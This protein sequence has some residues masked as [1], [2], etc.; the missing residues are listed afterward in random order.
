MAL[1]RLAL[2]L[3]ALG[4]WMLQAQ[5]KKVLYITHSAGFRHDCLPLSQQVM[6]D[7]AA[8]SGKLEITATQD[9]AALSDLS[10]YSAVTFFTSGELPLSDSQKQS[11]LAFVRRGGGF[12]GFHSATDTLYGWPE[13]GELI[14]GRFDG[15]PWTQQVRIDVEDPEHPA[16]R[17][18]TP[19]FEITEEI[20]QFREFSRGNV[21]ALMTLDTG[22]VELRAPGVNRMDGDFAL[23]WTRLYGAG[24]VFYTALGHFDGTWQDAR[25]QQMLEQ[26]LLWITGQVDGEG[27]PRPVVKPAIAPDGVGNAATLEPRMAISPGSLV[28]IYGANL[29][30]GASMDADVRTASGRLAGTRV[31]MNGQ[32]VPVVFASPGQINFLASSDLPDGAAELTVELPGSERATATVRVADVTPGIFT[33]T[34]SPPYATLWA[35]GLGQVRASGSLFETVATP[36]VSVNGVSAKVLFSGLAPGWIGLYQVNV[37]LPSA[38]SPPYDFKL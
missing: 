31:W 4:H 38:V 15:H 9:L 3:L 34:I 1:M 30:S 26:G 22:S 20:Y 21:R 11:L 13:Y 25:F 16:T 10:G 7:V 23:A 14:G 27:Q 29:T 33:A 2:L 17:H 12:A 28:S 6:R 37:E 8:R 24:R 19:S 18:L 35:T 32:A 36:N 5:P